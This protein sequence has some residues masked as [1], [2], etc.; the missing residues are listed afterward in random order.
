M[1]KSLIRWSVLG[2]ILLLAATTAVAFAQDSSMARPPSVADYSVRVS[3]VSTASTG[4]EPAAPIIHVI[5][6]GETLSIIARRY[7][8]GVWQIANYNGIANPDRI[9]AGQILRIPP[10]PQ[11]TPTPLP[12]PCEEIVI[13][14][15]SRGTAITSP[16]TV[17]GVASSPFEQTVVVAVLDGSGAQIG[18]APGIIVGEMGERG[19]FTVT[20]PFTVP[21]NSQPGR[22]QVFTE[23]PMDGALE[24]LSSVVVKLQGLDI[25]ALLEDLETAIPAKDYATLETLMAPQFLLGGYQ[26]EWGELPAA[27]ALALLRGDYLGPGSPTLDFSVDARQMLGERATFPPEVMHVVFCPGWG[28]NQNDDAFLLFGNVADRAR[29]TGL[30]YVLH[31]LIDYR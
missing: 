16:V 28:V 4:A 14:S 9:Y 20:V 26:S 2:V 25:D 29:W 17:I 15:P 5:K 31:D 11:P 19:P 8:V 3:L 1:H 6:R 24:H 30:L 10:P 21:S 7:G 13:S 22:I 18:I 12:C 23:S 27:E